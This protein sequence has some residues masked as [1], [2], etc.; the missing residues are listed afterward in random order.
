MGGNFLH[1]SSL[2]ITDFL[3]SFSRFKSKT[4]ISIT[5]NLLLLKALLNPIRNNK[6]RIR[7]FLSLHE[8]E[9]TTKKK[10]KICI[11]NL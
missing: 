6:I 4:L 3:V 10:K 11:I 9:E 7:L 5:L 1:R 2:E 8:K